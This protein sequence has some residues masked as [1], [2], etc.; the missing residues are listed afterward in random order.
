MV[1]LTFKYDHD[2]SHRNRYRAEFVGGNKFHQHIPN[3]T[4]TIRTI[5]VTLLRTFSTA[6]VKKKGTR[7]HEHEKE[8]FEKTIFDILKFILGSKPRSHLW[9]LIY[10]NWSIEASS[11]L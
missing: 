10:R 6:W 9:I 2:V 5:R 4:V 1:H 11:L 3:I 8:W 7:T